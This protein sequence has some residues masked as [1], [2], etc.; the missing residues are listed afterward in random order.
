[1]GSE[2]RLAP[3]SIVE[4]EWFILQFSLIVVDASLLFARQTYLHD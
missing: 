3:R 1:M 4:F 2:N